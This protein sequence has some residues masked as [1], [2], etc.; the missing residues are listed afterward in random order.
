MSALRS[1]VQS[2]LNAARK[3][4]DGPATL[5][6][7][8][9]LADMLNREIEL[10]REIQDEDVVDVL[11]RGI[12]RR[13]ESIEMYATGKRDDLA[14]KEAA[15]V[16][17]LERYLPAQV[18]AEDIRAAV[19]AAMAGGATNVGAIMGKVMPAFKGRADGG[20]ISAIVKEEMA[21]AG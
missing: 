12:K 15:E 8:T 18:N 16:V 3:A 13:R 6:L 11:R 7:G 9:V 21:S 2:E 4:H 19:R 1:R 17:L 14:A 5:L 20:Q 10:R